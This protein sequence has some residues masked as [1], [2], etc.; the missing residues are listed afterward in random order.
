MIRHYCELFKQLHTAVISGKKAPHKAV[1]LLSIIELIEESIISSP[2]IT[3]SDDLIS[4]FNS[5]WDSYVHSD[6]FSPTIT[7]PYWHLQNESFWRLN[8]YDGS[9]L[10]KTYSEKYLKE[11]TFAII[12]SELFSLAQNSSTAYLLKE[13]L[14]NIYII[15]NSQ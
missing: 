15:K 2:C 3:L 4:R 12:D 11:N 6:K 1:L 10:K 7:T 14:K 8:T 9:E 13:T 5:I